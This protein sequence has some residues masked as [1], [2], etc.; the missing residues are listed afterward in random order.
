MANSGMLIVGCGFTGRLL[1]QQRAFEGHAVYG[2]S[3]TEEGANVIRTRGANAVV[4]NAPDFKAIDRIKGKVKALVTMMPPIMARDGSYTDHNAA[5][6]A[7]VRDWGLEAVVYVS[8][9]SVYGDKQGAVVDEATPCTPDSP[10]GTARLEI[11]QQV[12]ESGLPAMVVRPAGIYGR[13][14]SQFD[15]FAGRR[16]RLIDGGQSYTNRIHVRDLAA[17]IAAACERGERGAIYLGTDARP[18]VQAEVAAHI[19]ETYGLPAPAELS[20]A[21]ARVRL[22]RDVLAM[23]MG[24]KQLDGSKTLERLGVTLR[25]PDYVAG[26]A[27]IWRFDE[28]AIRAAV[29]AE[30]QS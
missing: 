22:S 28:P 19:V 5:L 11:E 10:R 30:P 18:S 21:E 29:A 12:L 6:M 3:R 4:M 27:E 17:I 20:L 7:H 24:S 13:F 26:L 9:T 25:F 16:T 8:S 1:A 23:I 15:R 2:T 14:R